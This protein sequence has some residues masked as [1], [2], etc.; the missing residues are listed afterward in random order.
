MKKQRS[1]GRV[2]A[3]IGNPNV[4]KSTIFNAITGMHQHTGNWPGKTVSI[5]Q[6]EFDFNGKKYDLIDLPGSYSLSTLSAEEEVARDFIFFNKPDVVV[7][8]CDATCLERNLNIALQIIASVK[9]VILCINLMDQAKKRGLKINCDKLSEQLG[10]CVVGISAR[11]K[12][13]IHSLIEKIELVCQKNYNKN[14]K[15][16]YYEPIQTKVENLSKYIKTKNINEKFVA[17]KLL[18]DDK[19]FINNLIL[20]KEFQNSDSRELKLE[21]ENCR[22]DLI[23]KYSDENIMH[24]SLLSQFTKRAESISKTCI[25]KTNKSKKIKCLDDFLTNKWTG[26]PSII[27]LLCVVFW[28]T[29]AGANAPSEAL[30]GF[31]FKIQDILSDFLNLIKIPGWIEGI[32]IQGMFRTLAWV[33]SVMLPPMAIFFPI[34][35]LLEDFGYLPR[36]A[37]HLDCAFKKAGACGKQALTTCGDIFLSSIINYE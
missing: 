29:I 23:K 14:A 17:L 19:N 22:N 1:S 36:V 15:F 11:S 24:D 33:I 28:I 9:N 4:G 20:N 21:L 10:V 13:N 35:T 30:S 26:L 7:V 3:L 12:K 6:G 5:A 32:L 37:F 2:V 31:L 16:Q 27:L 34:F 18:S 8:V 25:L